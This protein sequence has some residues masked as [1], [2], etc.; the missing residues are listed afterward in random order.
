MVLNRWRFVAGCLTAVMC[1]W[2]AHALTITG[3]GGIEEFDGIQVGATTGS[4]ACTTSTPFVVMPD[5]TFTFEAKEGTAVFMFQGQFGGFTSS[6]AVRPVVQLKV[7]G[8]VVGLAVLGSDVRD[9]PTP[10]LPTPTVSGVTT[11]GYNAFTTL[12]AGTHTASVEWHTF[13]AGTTICVEERSLIVLH[14]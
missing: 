10:S 14:R 7:D 6:D 11:F 13:P 9:L 8:Q 12:D 1:G 3:G 5:T 4:Q 2:G